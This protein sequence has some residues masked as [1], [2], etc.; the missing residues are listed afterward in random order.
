MYYRKYSVFSDV[1]SFA[2]VLYEIWSLG[3]KPFEDI[4]NVEVYITITLYLCSLLLLY[5][6]YSIWR[7]LGVGTGSHLLLVVLELYTD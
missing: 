4:T 3:C 2:C 7:K 6:I 1:W 5:C